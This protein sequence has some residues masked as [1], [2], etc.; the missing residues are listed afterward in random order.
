LTGPHLL[1]LPEVT[2]QPLPPTSTSTSTPTRVPPGALDQSFSPGASTFRAAT[3]RSARRATRQGPGPEL[4]AHPHRRGPRFHYLPPSGPHDHGRHAQCGLWARSA[5][6][7]QRWSAP[8][9]RS[10]TATSAI[11]RSSRGACSTRPGALAATTSGGSRDSTAGRADVATRQGPDALG[12]SAI[13]RR[14]YDHV[15]TD[16]NRGTSTSTTRRCQA[17]HR[18]G[19]RADGYRANHARQFQNRAPDQQR[20]RGISAHGHFDGRGASATSPT[21]CFHED[22]RVRLHVSQDIE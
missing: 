2:I 17:P 20:V 11:R 22:R 19:R 5:V 10:S 7:R 3:M 8:C 14:L 4:P 6:S 18:R 15:V 1:R 13:T 16:I 21:S 12:P 9:A